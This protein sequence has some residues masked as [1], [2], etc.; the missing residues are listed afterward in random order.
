MPGGVVGWA[1]GLRSRRDEWKGL[2]DAR[3][4]QQE[5]IRMRDEEEGDVGETGP[6]ISQSAY[7]EVGESAVW[8][9]V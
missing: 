3:R 9:K 4:R 8:E 7:G 6:G 5:G 1:M 2:L